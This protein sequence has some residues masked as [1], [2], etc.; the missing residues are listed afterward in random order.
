M[1]RRSKP[2]NHAP[3]GLAF[4]WRHGE[5]VIAEFLPDGHSYEIYRAATDERRSVNIDTNDLRT[6]LLSGNAHTQQLKGVVAEDS[7][8]TILNALLSK[9][10]LTPNA[11]LAFTRSLDGRVLLTQVDRNAVHIAATQIQDWHLQQRPELSRAPEPSLTIDTRTRA[12]AR[13]CSLSA[14]H[15]QSPPPLQTT[16]LVVLG[17]E[18]YSFGLWSPNTGLVYE[19]E[20][21]FEGGAILEDKCE[22]AAYGL[23][24]LI[25]PSTLEGLNLPPVE[26]VIVSAPDD[27]T[28]PLIEALK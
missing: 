15:Q 6:T 10:S 1:L 19:T 11:A 26:K 8:E 18:D 25:T 22:Q 3:I 14:Y 20:E 16:A 17:S 13:V 5:I 27:A 28:V 4:D 9:A 2:T 21:N 12:I 23:S 24:R 7:D